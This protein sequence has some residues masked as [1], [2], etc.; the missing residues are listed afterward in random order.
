[1]QDQVVAIPFGQDETEGD[2]AFHVDSI[3]ASINDEFDTLLDAWSKSQGDDLEEW[4]HD[5]PVGFWIIDKKIADT[6]KNLEF[7]CGGDSPWYA[8][9]HAMKS[10]V[11]NLA[12]KTVVN[13]SSERL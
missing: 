10:L 1:M 7:D 4:V 2:S 3:Q 9:N 8:F 13:Q 11:K 12:V 5:M 6:V